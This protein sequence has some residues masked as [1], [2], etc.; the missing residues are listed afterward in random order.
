MQGS[1]MILCCGSNICCPTMI[2]VLASKKVH[3]YIMIAVLASK[4]SLGRVITRGG[5]R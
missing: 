3:N 1:N 2:A 4:K 5:D